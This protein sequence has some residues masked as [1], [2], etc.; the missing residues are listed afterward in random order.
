M[1]QF[2]KCFILLLILLIGNSVSTRGESSGE[3]ALSPDVIQEV[4]Q[5]FKMDTSTRALMNAL[6]N[7]EIKKLALNRQMYVAHDNLF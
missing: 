6:T 7:N 1:G 5:S 3:G 4:R 2:K